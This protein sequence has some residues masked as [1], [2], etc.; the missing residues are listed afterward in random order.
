MFSSIFFF[1]FELLHPCLDRL[2]KKPMKMRITLRL[3]SHIAERVTAMSGYVDAQST[4]CTECWRRSQDTGSS[5]HANGLVQ[6]EQILR[7]FDNHLLL[8]YI[9]PNIV[10]YS[11][12]KL[13]TVVYANQQQTYKNLKFKIT[14]SL[15]FKNI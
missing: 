13:V 8:I 7:R 10:K 9:K 15:T 1:F 3:T 5:T 2:H 14:K 6:D 4:E 12:S 11:R